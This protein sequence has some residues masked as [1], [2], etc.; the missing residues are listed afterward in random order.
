MGAPG[1]L[2]RLERQAAARLPAWAAP[3]AVGIVALGGCAVLAVVDPNQPGRYPLCPFRA[4][5]GLDCPGC[6][7]L[8]AI[9]ALTGGDLA[10]AAEHNLLTVVL[11]PVLTVAWLRW[12]G[13]S[14]GRGR[15]W[16]LPPAV[17]YGIVGVIAAFWIVRNL[18][19]TP[20]TWLASGAG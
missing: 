8:R 15:S 2:D 17:T 7:T 4:V 18:P 6:G 13:A 11:L 16:A 10:R 12:L 3:V 1:V 5:T 20:F 9:H 14:L 19:W